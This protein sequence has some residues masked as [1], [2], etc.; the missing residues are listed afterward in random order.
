MWFFLRQLGATVRLTKEE[1]AIAPRISVVVTI[2]VVAT[3]ILGA[4]NT[5]KGI[6]NCGIEGSINDPDFGQ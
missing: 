6:A 2:P 5:K 4:F 3:S 1:A